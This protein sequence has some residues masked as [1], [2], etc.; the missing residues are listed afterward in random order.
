MR[1]KVDEL[2][3]L[4]GEAPL[5][6]VQVDGQTVAAIVAAWTGVPL[7]RMVKDEISTVMNL[8]GLL[9]ERILGQGHASGIV[10]QRVR[11]ARANLEDPNKPKGVFLFVGTS[12]VGKTETALALADL[13][14]GG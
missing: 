8:Q 3:A 7:G 4:Q 12:G 5:V 13:L 6:P 2:H 9:D 14:Y 11:T 1:G 10:A